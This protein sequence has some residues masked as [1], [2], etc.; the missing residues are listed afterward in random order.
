MIRSFQH[1][2]L[3]V[4]YQRGDASGV[5]AD[6]VQRLQRLLASLEVARAP[7]DMDRPG[8]R[9]HPL[10]GRLN[11]FWAVNVSGNWRVVFR[12]IDSD[13]ELVDYLDYH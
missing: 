2:G 8:N 6:H 5:R 1:K 10:K 13:V 4:L 11:G 9:L 3:R 7:N 12:F